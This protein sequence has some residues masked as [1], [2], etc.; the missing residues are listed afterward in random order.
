MCIFP[1]FVEENVGKVVLILP[2][3]FSGECFTIYISTRSFQNRLFFML[4]FHNQ[5]QNYE[6]SCSKT[7]YPDCFSHDQFMS[8]LRA[9]SLPH[10]T[11]HPKPKRFDLLSG[12]ADYLHL[13]RKDRYGYGARTKNP[14]KVKGENSLKNYICVYCKQSM[15]KQGGLK[16]TVTIFSSNPK[17][18]KSKE[19]SYYFPRHHAPPNVKIS[20]RKLIGLGRIVKGIGQCFDHPVHDECYREMQENAR[21]IFGSGLGG[22]VTV[23]PVCG[24]MY[25]STQ[26]TTDSLAFVF[27]TLTKSNY[28]ASFSMFVDLELWK[29]YSATRC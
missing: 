24:H 2:P 15:V 27:L 10:S 19:E 11:Q 23:N 5:N 7:I 1:F 4:T 14:E 18:V 21:C 29:P 26:S 6:E 28:V 3:T 13:K 9:S 25:F 12:Q 17:A 8:C 22:D 20:T 16:S